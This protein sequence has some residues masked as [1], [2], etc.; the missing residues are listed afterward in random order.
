MGGEWSME[1]AWEE[2]VSSP[3]I[4]FVTAKPNHVYNLLAYLVED[5][6]GVGIVIVFLFLRSFFASSFLDRCPAIALCSSL[7]HHLGGQ[8]MAF[9]KVFDFVHSALSIM[10]IGFVFGN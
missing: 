6:I 10:T 8:D 5:N 9:W 2:D 1:C 3:I 7:S 4:A